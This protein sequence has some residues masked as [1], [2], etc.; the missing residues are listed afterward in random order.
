[1]RAHIFDGEHWALEREIPDDGPVA[2]LLAD[3]NVKH[4][5]VDFYGGG[6][7]LVYERSVNQ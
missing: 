5:T 7:V 1:V 2:R 3:D 6:A 4:V